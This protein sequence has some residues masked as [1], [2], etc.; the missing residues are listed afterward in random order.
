M[1]VGKRVMGHGSNGSTILDGSCGSRVRVH[2]PLTH[3]NVIGD[4]QQFEQEAENDCCFVQCFKIE[5]NNVL[6]TRECHWS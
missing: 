2:D 1:T 5:Q 6:L 4:C 3:D